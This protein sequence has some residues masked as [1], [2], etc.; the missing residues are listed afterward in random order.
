MI[1]DA[2]TLGAAMP[3]TLAAPPTIDRLRDGETRILLENIDWATYEALGDRLGG[4]H[5]RLTYDRGRLELMTKSSRHERYK[6]FT[7]RFL[8]E[9]AIE[10]DDGPPMRPYGETT[11]RRRAVDRGF[12]ADQCYYLDPA[13]LALLAGRD[14]DRPDDPLPDLVVEIEISESAIDKMAL[15]AALHIPEVWRCDGE[16]ATFEQLGPDGVYRS[17]ERSHYFPVSPEDW[18]YWLGECD[19]ADLKDWTLRLRAWIRDE[20]AN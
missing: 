11:W 8:G 12:E 2:P 9:L 5:V 1:P 14:P 16:A 4:Q 20:L 17:A 15:D 3:A 10:L 18:L 6:E 7:G 13:K 19:G